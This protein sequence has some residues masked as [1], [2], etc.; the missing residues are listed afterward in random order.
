[1]HQRPA[2]A[3]IAIPRNRHCAAFDEV[4]HVICASPVVARKTH[5]VAAVERLKQGLAGQFV[6]V[7][8]G[9]AQVRNVRRWNVGQVAQGADVEAVVLH[10]FGD[11]QDV[12]H[13]EMLRS[14][15]A[16][17]PQHSRQFG[18]VALHR[19]K[20]DADFGPGEMPTL[21][22]LTEAGQVFYDLR[23][24]CA[25]TNV[26]VT[27]RRRAVNRHPQHIQPGVDELLGFF[28]GQHRAIGNHFHARAESLHLRNPVHRVLM[29]EWFADATEVNG[30]RRIKRAQ[31]VEDAGKR[32]V[33]HA[34][35]W[36]FPRV[37][38]TG[39]AVN[40]AG[41][42]WLQIDLC[43]VGHRAVHAYTVAF[44]FQPHPGPRPQAVLGC[45]FGRHH[46]SS[47]LIHFSP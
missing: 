3:D 18:D 42:G 10:P 15:F 12:A 40:I 45:H 46:Q 41:D 6:E 39:D 2:G 23:Q 21:A 19:H 26:G 29:K 13:G 11:G 38:E 36:L 16:A 5:V 25:Q 17:N 9:Q 20:R 14:Q 33:R 4:A 32:F 7:H 47:L 35:Q 43:Q 8:L 31:A 1:M 24:F 44:R 22:H 30:R 28:L 34:A 37:A 27:L